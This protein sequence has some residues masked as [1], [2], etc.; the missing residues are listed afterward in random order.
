MLERLEEKIPEGTKANGEE[1]TE[2][3]AVTLAEIPYEVWGTNKTNKTN[4]FSCHALLG[5]KTL[6]A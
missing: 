6:C 3:K 2:K 1:G 4:T 5:Y